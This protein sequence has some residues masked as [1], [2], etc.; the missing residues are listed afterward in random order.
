M[1]RAVLID[2]DRGSRELAYEAGDT[3]MVIAVRNA[4]RGIE[5]RCGG[6][7]A[8]GTCAIEP[9]AAWLKLLPPMS[10]DEREMLEWTGRDPARARLSC[11]IALT[12]QLDGFTAVILDND[13]D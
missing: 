9:E 11:Q 10:E 3:L 4:V 1:P 8:C 6:A 5:A 7:R 12:A 2:A 13:I